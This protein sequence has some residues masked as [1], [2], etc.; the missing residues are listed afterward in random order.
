MMISERELLSLSLEAP[1]D[2]CMIKNNNNKVL[3][4]DR[5]EGSP[6]AKA[7]GGGAGGGGDGEGLVDI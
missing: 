1:H 6:N 7:A 4:F 5:W 2:V 3:I